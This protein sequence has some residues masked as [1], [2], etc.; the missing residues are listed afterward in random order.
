V[1]TIVPFPCNPLP[2]AF[3]FPAAEPVTGGYARCATFAPAGATA[4]AL[5]PDGTRAALL[6]GDGIARA[7][8][9]ASRQVVAVLAPAHASVTRAAFSPSGDA[10]LT[11]AG[12]EHEVTLWRA[13]DA[14]PVWTTTLPGHTYGYQDGAGAV[15]FAPDGLSVAVSPGTD[16]YLLDVATGTLR[17][18]RP[19][20]ALLDAA[21][22]WGGRRLV[23]ADGALSGHC[24]KSAVGGSIAALDPDTL[25]TVAVPM[26]WAGY[27]EDVQVPMFRASPS[28]DLVLTPPSSHDTDRSVRTF[29]LSDGSAIGRLELPSLPGA[30]MPDGASLLVM[31]GGELRIQRLDDGT[32]TARAP[33]QSPPFPAVP[34]FAVSADGATVAV[35]GPGPDVLDVWRTDGAAVTSVC[36]LDGSP[37]T[38]PL[39]LSG[40]GRLAALASGPD[41]RLVRPHDGTVAA[42]LPGD[43]RDVLKVTVSRTGRYVAAQLGTVLDSDTYVWRVADGAALVSLADHNDGTGYWSDLVFAPDERTFYA[44]WQGP[45]TSGVLHTFDL[46]GGG[47][48]VTHVLPG[49]TTIVGFSG[50]C[51]LLFQQLVGVRRMCDGY[52]EPAIPAAYTGMGESVAVSEHG[53]VLATR[54]P[55]G[56]TATLWRA[57]PGACAVRAF[58]PRA[59]E[60]GPPLE[61]P[62]AVTPG[63]ARVLSGAFPSNLSCYAGPGFAL[64]VQ[65]AANGDVLD[66]LPPAPSSLDAQATRIAYGTQVWCAR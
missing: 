56:P 16:L 48:E 37:A 3:V 29:K 25:A 34:I 49:V 40:D 42:T 63:G 1:P 2:P 50:G 54:D 21:Y 4:L 28:D 43:G 35:G 5:S 24:I 18:S 66:L 15:A 11:V 31:T 45:G 65:D 6:N 14:T 51:P 27:S 44:I 53:R 32:V 8:D 19:S 59:D 9:V 23:V 41:L 13:A 61:T 39:A 58:G 36:A 10:V 52:Q 12:G 22:A 38:L 64:R 57:P 7:V 17:A 55:S 47:L 26:T 30:F 33:F 60:P 20:A 62:Y 46:A